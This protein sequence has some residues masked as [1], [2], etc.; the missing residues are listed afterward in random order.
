MEKRAP[1]D[2]ASSSQQR[3][4]LCCDRLRNEV[5]ERL[6]SAL[7]ML[8]CGYVEWR[9]GGSIK[10]NNVSII[11]NFLSFKKAFNEKPD[12][13]AMKETAA[14][15]RVPLPEGLEACI[16]IAERRQ[17]KRNHFIFKAESGLKN[18][19]IT[20]NSHKSAQRTASSDSRDQQKENWPVQ[21][22]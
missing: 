1:L 21:G 17:A 7:S 19:E 22:S 6:L 11:F 16:N 14:Y 15:K 10:V 12:L 8:T 5:I 3:Q 2:Q 20:V 18:V 9:D 4:S 13:H